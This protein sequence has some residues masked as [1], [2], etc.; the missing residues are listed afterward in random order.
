MCTEKETTGGM[1]GEVVEPVANLRK[2]LLLPNCISICYSFDADFQEEVFIIATHNNQ[3]M[4]TILLF[5]LIQREE[6]LSSMQRYA[7]INKM[8]RTAEN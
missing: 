3:W 4:G 8:M 6:E 5:A 1:R 7:L 2:A